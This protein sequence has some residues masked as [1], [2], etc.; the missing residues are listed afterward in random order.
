MARLLSVPQVTST[1]SGLAYSRATKL[2]TGTVTIRNNGSATISG[3]FQV[4]LIGLSSGATLSN[5]T[6][7]FGGSPYITVAGASS[8]APGASVTVP[9]RFGNPSMAAIHFSPAIYTGGFN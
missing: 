2:F 6:G 8:L 3:P 1:A 5:A 7:N 9:V 4:L